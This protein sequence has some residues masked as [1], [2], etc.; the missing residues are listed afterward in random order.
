MNEFFQDREKLY[1][2]VFPESTISYFWKAN[3]SLSSAAFRDKKGLSVE[4][5]NFRDTQT[6]IKDMLS[7]FR[8][9]IV[10]V[11]VEQCKKSQAS[12]KYKPSERSVYHSEIHGSDSSIVLNSQQRNFLTKNAIIEY[13]GE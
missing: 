13:R 10:S 8:G 9:C 12:V 2:A 6:V 11:T 4:R 7:C 1:R 5:G 3:G